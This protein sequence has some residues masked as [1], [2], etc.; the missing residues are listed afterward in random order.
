MSSIRP[1]LVVCLWLLSLIAVH[2]DSPAWI[3]PLDGSTW[4][5]STGKFIRVEASRDVQAVD[6]FVGDVKIG[7]ISHREYA[8]PGTYYFDG[9]LANNVPGT[10]TITAKGDDGFSY[11]NLGDITIHLVSEDP[12]PT[13]TM[14]PA[15]EV[16]CCSLKLKANVVSQGTTLYS[17]L[18]QIS[19]SSTF[20]ELTID[21]NERIR[22]HGSGVPGPFP[23]AI[24]DFNFTFFQFP[25]YPVEQVIANL[26]PSTE[27]H[28]RLAVRT[29]GRYV[30][31]PEVVVT[32]PPNQPP[33]PRPDI[34]VLQDSGSVFIYC[35]DNDSD[36]GLENP[37]QLTIVSTSTASHG[38]VE[39]NQT[40]VPRLRYTAG[41]TFTGTDSF[42]YTV[43]DQFGAEATGTVEIR[44]IAQHY[45]AIAG[46][47]LADVSSDG[48]NSSIGTLAVTVTPTGAYSG[49]L[50]LVGV[51][52]PFTGAFSPHEDGTL[53][54]S[55]AF[56][57]FPSYSFQFTI[58]YAPIDGDPEITGDH[59]SGIV[60]TPIS[61]P[62]AE[63]AAEI[64]QFTAI[65]P[66]PN[67][68][69][70]SFTDTQPQGHAFATMKIARGGKV[71][72][73]GRTGDNQPFSGG[74]RLR[75]DHQVSIHARTA[76][77]GQLTGLLKFD[78]A[79][80]ING[81]GTVTWKNP[82]NR[83][84]VYQDPFSMTLEVESER[85]V[86]AKKASDL[87]SGG[88][89]L[90]FAVKDH[91]GFVEGMKAGSWDTHNRLDTGR[92]DPTRLSVT[93]NPRTGLFSG[94]YR[95]VHGAPR[96]LMGV[97]QPANGKG[98][99]TVGSAGSDAPLELV[100]Q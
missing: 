74:G 94:T 55:T 35:L 31:G 23:L 62:P 95:Q 27:Y 86:P 29:L 24:D 76:R 53:S 48:G 63:A 28:C 69:T 91:D 90:Q 33:T 89:T 32:T 80:G 52:H 40:G 19:T 17:T 98:S 30:Y 93:L 65:L 16:R 51:P 60:P 81:N 67:E 61:M 54:S 12:M 4:G 1:H 78:Q 44:S 68:A 87:L 34:A 64:G 39:I 58:D 79:G 46:S 14:E 42:T 36:D 41:E 83:G 88:P 6:F 26:E 47:Y 85:F 13:V 56:V 50:N 37:R 77:K 84:R 49:N 8:H 43:A 10:F 3:S 9:Y 45:A 59:G 20:P 100:T 72:V 99:G 73:V 66:N 5:S 7:R 21:P 11:T 96:R 70:A 82:A 22:I 18:F 71:A 75:K 57:S 38:T 92:S 15:T 25:Q 2:A 97:L